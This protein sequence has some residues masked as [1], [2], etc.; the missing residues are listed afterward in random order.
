[1]T[2]MVI[3][4]KEQVKTGEI[5]GREQAKYQAEVRLLWS[6]KAAVWLYFRDAEKTREISRVLQERGHPARTAGEGFAM[7]PG[8]AKASTAYAARRHGQ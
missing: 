5:T 2:D 6:K 1:M 7:R 8:H 3:A 4:G